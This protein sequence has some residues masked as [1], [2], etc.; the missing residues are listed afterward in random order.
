MGYSIY[1]NIFEAKL[2]SGIPTSVA[3]AAIGAGLPVSVATEFVSAFLDHPMSVA[4]LSGSYAF[5]HLG[6]ATV[7]RSSRSG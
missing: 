7:T 1:F 6:K 5:D 3:E 4:L 2:M